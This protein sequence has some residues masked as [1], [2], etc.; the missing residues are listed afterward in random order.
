M[1]KQNL[2]FIYLRENAQYFRHRKTCLAEFG[3]ATTIERFSI[4]CRKYFDEFGFALLRF[5]VTLSTNGRSSTKTNCDLLARVFPRLASATC[6]C[7]DW[8]IKII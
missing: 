3:M 2:V 6:L 4:E 1:V 5:Y 8:F 7:S